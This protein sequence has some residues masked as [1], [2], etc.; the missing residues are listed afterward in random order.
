MRREWSDEDLVGSWTLVDEDW[1]LVGN[2][3]GV[4]RLGFALLLKSFEI[5]G[6][7]RHCTHADIEANYVDTHGASVV[8]SPSPNCSDSDCCRG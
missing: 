2:K 8:G 3:S 4:T 5:E 6:L 7:L 1:Q